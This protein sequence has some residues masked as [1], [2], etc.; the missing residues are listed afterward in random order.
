M[1]IGKRGQI[2]IPKSIRDEFGFGPQTKVEFVVIDGAIH[3]KKAPSTL[4]LRKWKGYC[5]RSFEELKYKSVN[6]FI[7]DVR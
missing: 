1:K 3:L 2:T 4:N 5:G 7:D 6:E